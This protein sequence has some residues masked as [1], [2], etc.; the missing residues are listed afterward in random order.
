MNSTYDFLAR[1]S[2][3]SDVPDPKIHGISSRYQ[4]HHQFFG[5]DCLLSGIHY[6]DDEAWHYPG[7]NINARIKILDWCSVKY[8]VQKGTGF[9]IN[10]GSRRVGVGVVTAL[11]DNDDLKHATL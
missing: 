10:E 9:W 1:I 6:Y 5:L 11:A 8:F 4:P 3:L 7:E 2:L